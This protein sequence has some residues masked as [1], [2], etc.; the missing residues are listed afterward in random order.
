VKSLYDQ[1]ARRM[2]VILLPSQNSIQKN[3]SMACGKWSYIK[4]RLYEQKEIVL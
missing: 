1:L 4:K 3:L 2:M